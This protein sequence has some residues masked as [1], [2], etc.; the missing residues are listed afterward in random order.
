[1]VL[2]WTQDPQVPELQTAFYRRENLR[3][4]KQGEGDYAGYVGSM[5]HAFVGET[6]EEVEGKLIEFLG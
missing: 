6:P 1:M 2:D 5:D 3:I 4:E